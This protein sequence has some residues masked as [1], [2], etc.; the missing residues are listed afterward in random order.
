MCEL[1]GISSDKPV[2]PVKA[3][4]AFYERGFYN[5]DGVG[6][7]YYNSNRN[8]VLQKQPKM[9]LRSPLA[10][11][12]RM[13]EETVSDIFIAHVRLASPGLKIS[14]NNTHPFKEDAVGRE[15]IF[16]HNGTLYASRRFSTGEYNPRGETDSEY[17]FCYILSEI[18]KRNIA[19]NDE[20]FRWLHRI[21]SDIN[22]DGAFNMIMSDGEHLF[23]YNDSMNHNSGLCF[24]EHGGND[25]AAAGVVI[26]TKPVVHG[27]IRKFGN[28]E[29]KVFRKGIEVFSSAKHGAYVAAE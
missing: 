14:Y 17:A 5:P 7:A 3:L 23:C 8:A 15:Y 22:H 29:L 10:E 13:S 9:A 20:S 11:K 6:V 12:V 16:A 21:L 25:Y 27:E 18:S 1:F 26:S 19:W 28:G 4:R 24:V 2:R